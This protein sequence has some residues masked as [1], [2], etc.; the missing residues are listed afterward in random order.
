MTVKKKMKTKI[1]SKAVAIVLIVVALYLFTGVA[2]QIFQTLN[3][4]KQK[5][6]AEAE[7]ASL[8]EENASLTNERA[9]LED[10]GYV[11]TY[12]RGEYMFS[13]DGEQIF[14]LPESKETDDGE[15]K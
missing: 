4:Q 13:K 14:Y 15:K 1:L 3:L 10:P 8:K 2:K 12:A 6:I 7:L 9:K 11:E 5:E